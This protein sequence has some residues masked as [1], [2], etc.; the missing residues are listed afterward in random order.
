VLSQWQ[1][2]GFFGERQYAIRP[3]S[4]QVPRAVQCFVDHLRQAL[5]QG[6]SL[7]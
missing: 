4:A 5:A 2:R 1:P 3:W 6:F 7:A